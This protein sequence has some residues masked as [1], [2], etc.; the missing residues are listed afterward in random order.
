MEKKITQNQEIKLLQRQSIFKMIIPIDVEKKI[1]YACK[2][3]WN[4]EW[5]GTLFYTYKGSFE[6]GSLTIICK[7]IFIMD[8]GNQTYTEF[9]MSPDVISYMTENP[10][11]LDCQMGLIHSH[12][13]MSTFF[14]GTD[15][16]TL[17]E[18][19]IDRN[20]FVSLIVNNVGEYTAAITR[21]VYSTKNV[22]DCYNYNFFGEGNTEKCKDYKIEEN[23]IE[24][25]YLCI[26]KEGD[27]L[28]FSDMKNRFEEIRKRKESNK[29]KFSTNTSLYNNTIKYTDDKI[30]FKDNKSS[31]NTNIGSTKKES[32]KYLDSDYSD[33]IYDVFRF[34]PEIIK[35]LFFQLITGSITIN[36]SAKFNVDEWMKVMPKVFDKRFGTGEDGIKLFNEWAEVMVEFIIYHSDDSNLQS[37]GLNSD[38]ISSICAFNLIQMFNKYPINKYTSIYIDLLGDYIL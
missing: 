23:F 17:K 14:S 29:N 9:D 28:D 5:S 12:N 19:G 16:S 3:S 6:D 35:V 36:S 21:R 20:N 22:K 13:N 27:S 11:L 30:S 37:S 8:I 25:Y 2:E 1:R 4:T 10:D 38:M 15:T 33:D 24:W 34:D 7:D 18:E 32:L 31:I 26:T